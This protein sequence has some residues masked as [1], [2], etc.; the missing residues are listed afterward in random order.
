MGMRVKAE[1]TLLCFGVIVEKRE[2]LR[3]KKMVS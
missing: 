2:E 3:R 1:I